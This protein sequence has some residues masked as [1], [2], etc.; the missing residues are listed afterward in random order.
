MTSATQPR[1][2]RPQVPEGYGAPDTD[3]GLLPW[4]WAEQKL[5]E[6]PNYWFAT[7]RPNGRPHAS[8]IWGIWMDGALYFDGSPETRRM[9]NIAANP[10]VAVHLES[11]DEVVII[12]GAAGAVAAP[13]DKAL[14][15]QSHSGGHHPPWTQNEELSRPWRRAIQT[16]NLGR[17][18]R[19]DRGVE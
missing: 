9:K 16:S 17:R 7:V 3:E 13:P 10:N 6:A 19:L 18:L 12:E 8:P 2:E 11:G 14:A 4:E 1:V 5:T 15:E